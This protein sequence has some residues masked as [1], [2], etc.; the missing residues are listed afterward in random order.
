MNPHE[1][2]DVEGFLDAAR[3]AAEGILTASSA[4]VIAHIDADG[5]SAASIASSALA[6][7]GIEHRVRFVKK[8]DEEEAARANKDDSEAI[9][10][11]DL[12]SSLFSKLEHQVVCVTDHH[13]P[14]AHADTAL[15]KGDLLSFTSMG[16]HVNPHL[17]HIDGAIELSGAGTTYAVAKNMDPRNQALAPLAI[18]G[19]VGDLQDSATCRLRGLNRKILADGEHIGSLKMQRDLRLFGRE[20]RPVWRMLQYS[21]DPMLPGLTNNEE[22]CISFLRS[23]GIELK[24]GDDWRFWVDL[25]FEERKTIAT[26][27][28]ELLLDGGNGHAGVRRLIGEVYT[29]EKEAKRT[30]LHDAKEYSTLLNACGR[31]N[32]ASTGLSICCGDRGEA[33]SNGKIL[34]QNHRGNLAEAISLV[35]ELGVQRRG[36]LQWFHGRDEILDSIVGIVAGMVLGS[37]EV[38][39]DVPMVAFAFAEDEKVKVSTR[40]TRQLVESGL[41]LARAVKLASEKVGGIGGGHNIAAGATIAMGKEEEF[42]DAIDAVIASQLRPSE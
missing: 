37:G 27:L 11:V 16:F 1:P 18:V 35:R 41:D 28:C 25:T 42:L 36:H 39:M 3:E 4:T 31:Y 6:R 20:S 29:L 12:G 9:W 26:A 33:Y 7:A 15:P 5:V 23:L 13:I 22:G 10:L 21:T 19:A 32:R 34:L 17:F 2:Q 14:Q 40:G 30:E 8:L 38:P 24:Q